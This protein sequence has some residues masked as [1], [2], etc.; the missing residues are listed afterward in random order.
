MRKLITG[1]LILFALF[2]SSCFE[3]DGIVPPELKNYTVKTNDSLVVKLGYK[4]K[5]LLDDNLTL[6]FE[7]VA[8]DSRCPLYAICVWAGDGE[9][10]LSFSN[11][12]EITQT[13]L[14]TT[15]EPKSVL[16]YGYEVKL[17]SL[18]PYPEIDKVI[19]KEDYKI[20]LVIKRK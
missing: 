17:N 1:G 4:Q 3:H 19:K 6:T 2:L 9:V 11:N 12:E 13:I 7:D 5:I 18:M 15:L 20:E 14:H 10:I 16:I 8:A